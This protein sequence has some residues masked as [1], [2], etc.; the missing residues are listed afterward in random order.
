MQWARPRARVL[1]QFTWNKA[2]QAQTAAYASLLGIQRH[3]ARGEAVMELRS[4][5]S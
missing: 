1:K 4:P 5:T 2:F 3:T